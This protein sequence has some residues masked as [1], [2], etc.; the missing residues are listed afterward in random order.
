MGRVWDWPSAVMVRVEREMSVS[1]GSREAVPVWCW[2]M[3][4]RSCRWSL[5]ICAGGVSVRLRGKVELDT[6]VGDC[7]L[8][9][10]IVGDGHGGVR[11]LVAAGVLL[12][13]LGAVRSRPKVA[14]DGRW[15][16]WMSDVEIELWGDPGPRKPGSRCAPPPV[17]TYAANTRRDPSAGFEMIEK[18]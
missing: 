15:L 11:R 5:F 4:E 14:E 16:S 7:A 8:L 13:G 3:A 9:G 2:R 18:R 6:D 12:I 1:S 17:I 10:A